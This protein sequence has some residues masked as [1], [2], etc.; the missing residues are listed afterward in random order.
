[1]LHFKVEG[2]FDIE[3]KKRQVFVPPSMRSSSE[4]HIFQLIDKAV[5]YGVQHCSVICTH[6]EVLYV[7]PCALIFYRKL[8]LF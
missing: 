6:P 7:D 3:Q 4:E 5:V 1:M 8:L 2:K